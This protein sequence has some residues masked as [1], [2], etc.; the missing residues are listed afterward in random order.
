MH[1]VPEGDT[2]FLVTDPESPKS[3]LWRSQAQLEQENGKRKYTVL[4]KALFVGIASSVNSRKRQGIGY[5]EVNA[6]LRPRVQTGIAERDI[7]AFVRKLK[8][9]IDWVKELIVAISGYNFDVSPLSLELIE[10]LSEIPE[11]K[12]EDTHLMKWI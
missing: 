9:E 1:K 4:A 3:L 8:R 10:E 7:A 2:I 11:P 12:F 6:D 5:V